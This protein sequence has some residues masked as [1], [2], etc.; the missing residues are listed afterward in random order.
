M[1]SLCRHR[2]ITRHLVL[3]CLRTEYSDLQ[4]CPYEQITV[5]LHCK[6]CKRDVHYNIRALGVCFGTEKLFIDI[7]KSIKANQK[8]TVL[9]YA[10]NKIPREVIEECFKLLRGSD[11]EESAVDGVDASNGVEESQ[12]QIEEDPEIEQMKQERL[13]KSEENKRRT[14]AAKKSSEEEKEKA[15]AAKKNLPVLIPKSK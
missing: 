12:V 13:Q 8:S 11:A 7:K 9:N 4:Q 3:A 6:E 10:A 5:K 2:P 15:I 14:A 1:T